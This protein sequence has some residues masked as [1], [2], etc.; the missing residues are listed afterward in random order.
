[1][2]C[3][4][5]KFVRT[6]I[7]QE[8]SEVLHLAYRHNVYESVH[9]A[10][11]MKLTNKM[12]LYRLIYYSKSALH[13]KGNVFAHHQEHLTLFTVSGSIHLSC[14][15]LVSWMS[16]KWTMWIVR[17]VY[18][19]TCKFGWDTVSSK[20]AHYTIIYTEWHIPDVV[21][22]QLILLMIGKWLPETCR[23]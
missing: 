20:L 18:T 4:Y 10:T 23:E 22:I 13:V 9:R 1:M 12:Q 16:W 8:T 5:F 3:W 6:S 19:Q 21:L 14:G 15:R 17:R 2:P 11:I 7:L